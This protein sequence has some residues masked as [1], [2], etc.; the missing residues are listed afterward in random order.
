MEKVATEKQ[1]KYICD[2]MAQRGHAREG[3][4]QETARYVPY[5]STATEQDTCETWVSRLTSSQASHLISFLRGEG[6]ALSYLQEA[7]WDLKC[8]M[9]DLGEDEI[10]RRCEAKG[11]NIDSWNGSPNSVPIDQRAVMIQRILDA[12]YSGEN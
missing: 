12:V 6:V 1:V 2:L 4:L 9:V 7:Q 10:R 11:L 3:C 5:G 8:A